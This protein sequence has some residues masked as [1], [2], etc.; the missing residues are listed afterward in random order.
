MAWEN[1]DWKYRMESQTVQLKGDT[2]PGF[3]ECRNP[4]PRG[5]GLGGSNELNYMLYVRGTLGEY[6]VWEKAIGGE[7]RWGAVSMQSAKEEYEIKIY[8]TSKIDNDHAHS[9]AESRVQVAGKSAYVNMSKGE[10]NDGKEP[11]RGGFN[12]EHAVWSG[13]RQSTARQFLVPHFGI[14]NFDVVVGVVMEKA[15]IKKLEKEK[16]GSSMRATGIDYTFTSCRVPALSI[17]VFGTLI[18][19]MSRLFGGGRT[20]TDVFHIDGGVMARKEVI[21]TV[22]VYATLHI[23]L[24]VQTMADTILILFR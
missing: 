10:Y 17:P 3:K 5:K 23:L 12:H 1:I 22:G 4:I 18:P 2:P 15:M 6:A 21:L 8:H 14:E 20:A 11:H 7:P 19:E 9:L 16:D 13:V 24:K